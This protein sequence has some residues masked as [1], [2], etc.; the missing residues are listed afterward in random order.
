MTGKMY[1][2]TRNMGYTVDEYPKACGCKE[3]H[4]Y[5]EACGMGPYANG[6]NERW[7]EYCTTH[8]LEN[9]AVSNPNECLLC[10]RERN[11][12]LLPCKHLTVCEKCAA[13]IQK[14]PVCSCRVEDRLTIVK[15]V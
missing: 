6:R 2:E 7:N 4:G 13:C 1:S 15:S 8:L 3:F 9:R 14:C 12:V 10:V 11:T 5:D